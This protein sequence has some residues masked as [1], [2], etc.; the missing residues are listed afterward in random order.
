M[1]VIIKS[2][3]FDTDVRLENILAI[4]LTVGQTRY[5]VGDFIDSQIS[6]ATASIVREDGNIQ[7]TVDKKRRRRPFDGAFLD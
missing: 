4:P 2:S 7:I 1:N 5:L 3:K 6:N